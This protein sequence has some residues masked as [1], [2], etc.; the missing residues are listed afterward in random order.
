[1]KNRLGVEVGTRSATEKDASFPS[2][3]ATS[4]VNDC[5]FPANLWWEAS[6][7]GCWQ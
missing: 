6:F 4:P 7:I 1:V 2:L 5:R 3:H